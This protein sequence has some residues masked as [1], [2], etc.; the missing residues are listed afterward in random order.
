MSGWKTSEEGGLNGL[1][2][3]TE[4][5]VLLSS[6]LTGDACPEAHTMHNTKNGC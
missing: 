6:A 4:Q 3:S 2:R 1:Y 5:W